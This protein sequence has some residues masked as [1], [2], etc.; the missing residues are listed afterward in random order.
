MRRAPLRLDNDGALFRWTANPQII[1]KVYLR[2]KDQPRTFTLK[3]KD[4][5]MVKNAVAKKRWCRGCVLSELMVASYDVA[6]HIRQVR[7]SDRPDMP[8]STYA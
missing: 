7:Q 3:K 4:E 6:R 1:C 8:D 5:R 2:R